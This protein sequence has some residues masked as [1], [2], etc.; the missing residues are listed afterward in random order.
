MSPE[1]Y[2]TG[3]SPH[4][5]SRVPHNQLFPLFSCNFSWFS[6]FFFCFLPSSCPHLSFS[7]FYL[8]SKYLLYSFQ[9]ILIVRILGLFLEYF[10]EINIAWICLYFLLQGLV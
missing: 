9:F 6:E 8:H 1:G 4:L 5:F 7:A 2:P 10:V 3:L